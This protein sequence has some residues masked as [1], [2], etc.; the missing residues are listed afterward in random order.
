MKGTLQKKK[1]SC[2][3]GSTFPNNCRSITTSYL[4]IVLHPD[5]STNNYHYITHPPQRKGMNGPYQSAL[6][7]ISYHWIA[8]FVIILVTISVFARH[9]KIFI[10]SSICSTGMF[11]CLST[12][13]IL[14]STCHDHYELLKK[15]FLYHLSITKI[16]IKCH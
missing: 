15:S 12:Y 6:K 4:L 13:S 1:S 9:S 10:L 11:L 2:L 3:H 14:K 8:L 5:V 16:E 7:T